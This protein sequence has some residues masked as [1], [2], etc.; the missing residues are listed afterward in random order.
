MADSWQKAYGELR[1]YLAQHPEIEVSREAVVLPG[2]VRQEFYR[3]FN[4]ARQ[5]VLTER[6]PTLLTDAAALSRS[7]QQAAQAVSQ[8][9]GLKEIKLPSALRWFLADPVDGLIRP[10]FDP[11]FDLLKGKI[12]VTRFEEEAAGPVTGSFKQLFH[13][14][15]ER[16]ALLALVRQLAPD[17]AWA[18][19]PSDFEQELHNL[20]ADQK[21]GYNAADIP[22]PKPA[23]AISLGHEGGDQAYILSNIIVHAPALGRYVGLALDLADAMWTA[24]NPSLM[25]E[26]LTLR[27]LGRLY[28]PGGRTWSGLA[29]YAGEEPGVLG[30][31][32]DFT[33]FQR[34]DI[35]VECLEQAD[36]YQQGELRRVRQ[37]HDFL[38]PRLGSFV[39]SRLPVPAEAFRELGQAVDGTPLVQP[40]GAASPPPNIRLLSVGYDGAQL[41]PIVAALAPPPAPPSGGAPA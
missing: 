30:L 37:N 13:Q 38:K 40:E 15:Y 41:A 33:R 1:A 19:A 26:W 3:R 29:I 6:Y 31:A 24:K 23:E 12:D 2:E 11:L 39:I 14:G 21:V 27:E 5:A 16:W 4:A 18:V 35:F 22:A 20:E 36:W 10:L 34:P 9:L 8:A 25:R 7:Y 17:Q 28:K 32:A